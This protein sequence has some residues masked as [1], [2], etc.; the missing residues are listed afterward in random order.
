MRT[1][2]LLPG[3]AC[4]AALWSAQTEA[5]Q[6]DCDVTVSDVHQRHAGLPQ[7]ASALLAE[8]RGELILCGAS[9]GGMLAL[10]V[11]RQAPRRVRAMAL[12]GSSARADTPEL[13]RLR[14]DAIALYEQGRWREVLGANVAF[15]FEPRNASADPT[16]VQ[17]YLA[18]IERAGAQQLIAQNRAVM[19]R[20]DSRPLLPDIDCPVLVACGDADLLT[21]P[22]HSSEMAALLPRAELRI[23]DTC[24]HMLTMERPSQVNALLRDWLGRL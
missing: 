4:D 12:L 23:V 19:A 3:L 7:M 1:I 21:P 24:G 14:G 20:P 15:A 13:L 6:A 16:L 8:Q 18:M 11:W 9:M 2:T 22:D 5:L 17:R 10:E